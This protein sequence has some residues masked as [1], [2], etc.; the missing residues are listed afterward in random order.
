MDIKL[1]INWC[2]RQGETGSLLN[3]IN[4]HDDEL[5]NEGV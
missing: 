3:L 5:N 2:L 4:V 1:L